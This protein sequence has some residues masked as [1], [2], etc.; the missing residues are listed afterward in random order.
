MTAG[1]SATPDFDFKSIVYGPGMA[2]P[3]MT[4]HLQLIGAYERAI[5]S[6]GGKL[7]IGYD[8]LLRQLDEEWPQHGVRAEVSGR[9][10][11]FGDIIDTDVF[12]TMTKEWGTPTRSEGEIYWDVAGAELISRGIVDDG[13]DT[14][15]RFVCAYSLKDD[16]VPSFI[17]R[18]DEHVATYDK[19][20]RQGNEL[21]L[22]REWPE[23]IEAIEQ[24]L[25]ETSFDAETT[26][27]LA[28]AIADEYQDVLTAYDQLRH[29]LS[30]YLTYRAGF[31][32]HAPYALVLQGD[33]SYFDEE[34]NRIPLRLSAKTLEYVYRPTVVYQ[35][36]EDEVSVAIVASS[37]EGN[38]DE[39]LLIVP[40]ETIHDFRPTYT[41]VSLLDRVGD[42]VEHHTEQGR[43]EEITEEASSARE[44]RLEHLRGIQTE[45]LYMIEQAR[46]V[47]VEACNSPEEALEIA[48]SGVYS[49]QGL[50]EAIGLSD[51]L[52]VADG[53]GIA[54][55]P[56]QYEFHRSNEGRLLISTIG[57]AAFMELGDHRTGYYTDIQ[58][59]YRI[60]EEDGEYTY[61]PSIVMRLL[62]S[63]HTEETMHAN[64]MAM[65]ETTLHSYAHVPLESATILVEQLDNE[66]LIDQAL[67]DLDNEGEGEV[68]TWLEAIYAECF[69]PDTEELTDAAIEALHRVATYSASQT[70]EAIVKA[71][72]GVIDCILN[73]QTVAI[74]TT[75]DT[76]ELVA[77]TIVDV[78]F[79]RSPDFPPEGLVLTL[80]GS[81]SSLHSVAVPSIK[82]IVPRRVV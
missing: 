55:P 73:N 82:T 18:P 77:G 9:L 35:C 23:L 7:S 65:V 16:A 46:Q 48:E 6:E 78:R 30:E 63:S 76:S 56:S 37:G 75:E 80:A 31:S 66:E 10:Y 58:A 74:N 45:I 14:D 70:N 43:V 21:Y 5:N 2:D 36:I 28:A 60:M 19:L 12:D 26:L 67:I 81:D 44:E 1:E 15:V 53:E 54:L 32:N 41:G 49:I 39:T 34:E 42:I 79:E 68:C 22:R 61:Y 4:E 24:G 33:L 25:P 72:V 29:A 52:L 13:N 20:T 17:T 27:Y 62:V 71:V 8:S 40:F 69:D 57:E 64:E 38:D 51:C 11:L 47:T 59:S 3:G 50:A